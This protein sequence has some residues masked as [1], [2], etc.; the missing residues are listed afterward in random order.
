MDQDGVIRIWEGFQGNRADNGQQI[1]WQFET[2]QHI[3][4]ASLFET[5]NFRFARLCLDQ[6]Y[7]NLSFAIAWRGM[8]GKW[9]TISQ[10]NVTA[11][12]GGT[13]S[14]NPSSPGPFDNNSGG[15]SY[16]VQQR[17]IVTKDYRGVHSVGQAAGVE[18]PWDDSRDHAFS[19]LINMTGRAAI[20]GYR[21]A[22]DENQTDETEG[23]GRLVAETGFHIVPEAGDPEYVAGSTPNFILPNASQRDA[24]SPVKDVTPSP[25][26]YAC[27]TS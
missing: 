3:A 10:G 27:P 25:T 23:N 6:V 21:I 19:L 26:L 4:A 12:P 7:G 15:V 9:H 1:P 17:D 14:P 20:L 16:T 5:S 11:T 8:R 18:S 22:V 2:R 13:L 24:F